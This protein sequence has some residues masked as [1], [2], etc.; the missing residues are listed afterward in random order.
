MRSWNP[1]YY[2]TVV[3]NCAGG[4]EFPSL[5]LQIAANGRY[6]LREYTILCKKREEEGAGGSLALTWK[7]TRG[8]GEK[9]VP[10]LDVELG[11]FVEKNT[12]ASSHQFLQH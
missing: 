12:F 1:W 5:P 11:H 7:L 10:A 9:V 6:A 2:R 8:Q 4:G 3:G